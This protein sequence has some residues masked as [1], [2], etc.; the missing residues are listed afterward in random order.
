[1]A[2][3]V[4]AMVAAVVLCGAGARA[5]TQPLA[6]WVQMVDGGVAE[7]RAVAAG[8]AC[9]VAV[10]DGR[11]Q[12]MHVRAE[13][14]P[15][16][17]PQAVCALTLPGGVASIS[18]GGHALTAPPAKIDRIV[19]MGDTGCRLKGQVVQDCND[20]RAWPFALVMKRAAAEK[21]DLVIHVGDYY[22]REVPCPTMYSGCA[23]SPH[24]D[25]WPS[26]SEDFFAPAGPLLDTAPWVFARGNH[27]DCSRGWKGWTRLLSAAPVNAICQDAD[28]PFAVPIGG[29][30]TLR[31]LDSA[32]ADDRLPNKAMLEI[33]NRQIASL[34]A[35]AAEPT[36]W[37]I[38]HRPIWGEAPVFTLGPLGVF[39]VGLNRTEQIAARGKDLSS[40]ALVLSGHVHH[41]AS[42]DFGRDRPAQLV[43]GTGGD[44][45]ETFDPAKMH[46]GA[47][48]IDGM[49]AQ[50]LT[51]RQYG[52]FV[53]DRGPSGWTGVFKDIDGK[54]VARCTLVGRKLNCG[55]A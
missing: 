55:R 40:V 49:E 9:P 31:V 37:V 11:A 33:M 44:L 21:P 53:M 30:V 6:S 45:G 15:A 35:H 13:A 26:W 19:V 2:W 39:N 3:R 46:A 32:V 47:V 5:Q 17:F 1:M 29:G 34:P 50:S 24:G 10:I 51:F 28:A 12:L 42:F 8:A 22:Y 43:V 18:I 38:T 54:A 27:E 23:G 14:A 36:D 52:Y 4:L 41:F 7:A 25:L 48:F 20:V 16:D